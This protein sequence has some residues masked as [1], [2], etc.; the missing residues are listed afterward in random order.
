MKQRPSSDAAATRDFV[1]LLAGLPGMRVDSAFQDG[2]LDA[3]DLAPVGRLRVD[4]SLGIE[5]IHVPVDEAFAPAWPALAQGALG[6]LLLM[7]RPE[8]DPEAPLRPLIETLRA[9]QPARLFHVMLLPKGER[10]AREE[11]QPHLSLLDDASLILLPV[12]DGRDAEG[13]LRAMIT[14]VLP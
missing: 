12:E 2:R 14:R 1:R 8:G 3:S 13:L 7:A 6:T 9:R 11:L 5:L 4:E 10:L